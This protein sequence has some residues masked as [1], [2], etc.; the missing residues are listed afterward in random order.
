MLLHEKHLSKCLPWCTPQGIFC[1]CCNRAT[2]ESNED[3]EGAAEP[4]SNALEDFYGGAYADFVLSHKRKIVALFGVLLLASTYIW[5]Q[6]LKPA[7]KP[8]TFFDEDH[9]YSQTLSTMQTKF[10]Y[11]SADGKIMLQLSFGLDP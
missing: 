9:F 4:Q 6:M 8:F 11:E 1:C 2:A 7:T 3:S 5:T 10:A